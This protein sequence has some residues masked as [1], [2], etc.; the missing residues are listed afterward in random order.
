MISETAYRMATL[1]ILYRL[2]RRMQ[3]VS[4][5]QQHQTQQIRGDCCVRCEA[6]SGLENRSITAEAIQENLLFMG[7]STLVV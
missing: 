2:T 5:F 3:L 1:C 4:V 6:A 7:Q